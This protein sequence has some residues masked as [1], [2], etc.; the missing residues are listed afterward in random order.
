MAHTDSTYGRTA[1]AFGTNADSKC[2]DN[3]RNAASLT[4]GLE[5]RLPPTSSSSAQ[6]PQ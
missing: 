5:E 1:A 6:R 3:S 4:A 2:T